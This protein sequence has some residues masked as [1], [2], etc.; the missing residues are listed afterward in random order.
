MELLLSASQRG[1]DLM[2][3]V[4]FCS[5]RGCICSVYLFLFFF[6]F[7][8]V[9]HLWQSST[10]MIIQVF[11]GRTVF[12]LAFSF[13]NIILKSIRLIIMLFSGALAEHDQ[14][15]SIMHVRS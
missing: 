5:V 9:V 11:I 7:K 12:S 2:Q 6:Y 15:S 10:E 8:L 13:L 4:S 1:Q 14:L 3:F